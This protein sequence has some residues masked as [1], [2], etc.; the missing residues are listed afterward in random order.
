MVRQHKR[1]EDDTNTNIVHVCSAPSCRKTGRIGT[2][3]GT[4]ERCGRAC[5]MTWF[6]GRQQCVLSFSYRRRS[7]RVCRVQQYMDGYGKSML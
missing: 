1:K 3:V 5:T 4:G 6:H 7:A 2:R